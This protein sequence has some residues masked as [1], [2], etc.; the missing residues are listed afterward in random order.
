MEGA[1]KALNLND[2]QQFQLSNEVQR[3]VIYLAILNT[4]GN[5]HNNVDNIAVCMGM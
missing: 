3:Y 4:I 2:R 5:H 1:M